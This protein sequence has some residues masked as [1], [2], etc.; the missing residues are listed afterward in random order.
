MTTSLW[1][2]EMPDGVRLYLV[3]EKSATISTEIHRC[4]V[5]PADTERVSYQLGELVI[6]LL[7]NLAVITISAILNVCKVE[8]RA[9]VISTIG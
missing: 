1:T 9:V 4:D 8:H 3:V 6:V 5:L 2:E 7:S